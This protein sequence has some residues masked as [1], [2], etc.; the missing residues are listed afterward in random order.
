MLDS[1]KMHCDPLG[2]AFAPY[3][4]V[5]GVKWRMTISKSS[6]DSAR[7]ATKQERLSLRIQLAVIEVSDGRVVSATDVGSGI[8]IRSSLSGMMTILMPN[9]N[10]ILL[11]RLILSRTLLWCWIH[12]RVD[13]RHWNFRCIQNSFRGGTGTGKRCWVYGTSSLNS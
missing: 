4:F 2:Y 3:Y 8:E 10:L 9:M 12:Q 13:D 1:L 5:R 6:S 7:I 11:G